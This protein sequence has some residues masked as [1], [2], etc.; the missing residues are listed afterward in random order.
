VS[1]SVSDLQLAVLS[2]SDQSTCNCKSEG[3]YE[4]LVKNEEMAADGTEPFVF[5]QSLSSVCL[6]LLSWVRI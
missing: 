1:Y 4:E 2:Y 6:V 3:E 5:E